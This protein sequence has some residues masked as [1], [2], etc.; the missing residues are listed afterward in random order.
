MLALVIVGFERGTKGWRIKVGGQ[1]RTYRAVKFFEDHLGSK[2]AGVSP[3]LLSEL[4]EADTDIDK[5][6]S[7]PASAP[8]SL[9]SASGSM[10]D[11]ATPTPS[12]PTAA[13]HHQAAPIPAI[14][15]PIPQM[16]LWRRVLLQG[17]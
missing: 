4:E 2:S 12:T 5:P 6:D 8:V 7:L 14:E 16:L 1:I 11:N 17:K 13:D 9:P 10:D 3:E 15:D